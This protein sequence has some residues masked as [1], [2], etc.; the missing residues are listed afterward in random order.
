VLREYFALAFPLMV[1]QSVTVLDEQFPRLFG[2]LAGEGGTAAL[3]FARMLNMLPVG[4]IAQAAGVATFPFLARLVA[5]GRNAEA[6]Q[7]TAKALRTT[8]AF[9]VGAAAVV[10]AASE[11]LV[12]MVFQWGA[13]DARDSDTVAGLLPLFAVSIPAWA[14]HQIVSRWF[15]AHRRMWLPVITGTVATL[16]AIPV[17]LLLFDLQG[18][19]GIAIASTLVMW[20][21]TISLTISWRRGDQRPETRLLGTFMR[22]GVAGVAAGI[23]GRFLADRLFDGSLGSALFAVSAVTLFVS[24]VF[25][26]LA[27]LLG[28]RQVLPRRLRDRG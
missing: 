8:V 20:A 28:L 9:A 15:Y 11:P 19:Q 1:G 18:L 6:D 10:F 27:F 13:F 24:I 26:G 25:F 23:S 16:V 22:L 17:T 14:I 3:S 7:T 2:Q 5:G 4:I 21:Y 12:R